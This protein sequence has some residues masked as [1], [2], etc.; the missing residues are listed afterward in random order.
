MIDLT[1][2]VIPVVV[3]VILSVSSAFVVARTAGPSQAAY[4]ASLE[5]R[6]KLVVAER[7]EALTRLRSL[8]LRVGQLEQELEGI[9][10]EASRKDRQLIELYRRIDEDERRLPPRGSGR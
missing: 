6:L 5:G 10:D 3:A 8:E 4:V 9:R 2:I 1:P 7:D